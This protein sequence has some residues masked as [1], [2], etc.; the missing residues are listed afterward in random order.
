MTKPE[1][2]K[3]GFSGM[4]WPQY[5]EE[6][7]GFIKLLKAEGCTSYMEIGCRYGDTWHEVGLALP[8]GSKLVAVDLPGSKSGQRN[9]GGHQ[10]S[11]RFLKK[12]RKDLIKNGRNAIVIIGDSQEAETISK[13]KELAPFYAILIDGDHT[14]KGVTRDLNNYSPMARIIAFHDVCGSGKWAKQIRPI[15]E[16]YAEGKKSVIFKQDGLRRGIGVVWRI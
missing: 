1:S 9:K 15:F 6:I 16:K 4:P 7:Q 13:V 2:D 10:N 11:G 12:A 5:Q 3:R 8:M 14:A